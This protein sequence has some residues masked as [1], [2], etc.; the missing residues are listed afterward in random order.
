M[1]RVVIDTNVLVSALRS[2]MGA[3]Y[4]LI[5]MLPSDRFELALSVPLYAE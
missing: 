3:A 5:S 1:I 2:N 4:P